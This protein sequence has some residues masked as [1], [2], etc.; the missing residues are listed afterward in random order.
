[1]AARWVG[2]IVS[3]HLWGIIPLII[4]HVFDKNEQDHTEIEHVFQ[5]A[6][7]AHGVRVIIDLLNQSDM[8]R[9]GVLHPLGKGYVVASPLFCS[10]LTQP[11]FF[12][13]FVA[14]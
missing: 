7:F 2:C 8:A 10:S 6:L 14:C 11:F 9:A 5:Q 3:V 1:M 12:P 4:G 13:H